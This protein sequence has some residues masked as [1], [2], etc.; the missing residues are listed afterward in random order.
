MHRRGDCRVPCCAHGVAVVTHEVVPVLSHWQ[1]SAWQST[2]YDQ[3][4]STF[5]AQGFDVPVL[6]GGTDRVPAPAL[7]FS[8]LPNTEVV[9]PLNNNGENAYTDALW[10]SGTL[11]LW[12]A[13][14]P[15]NDPYFSLSI[16]PANDANLMAYMC[17]DIATNAAGGPCIPSNPAIAAKAGVAPPVGRHRHAR[18]SLL[19]GA[20]LSGLTGGSAASKTTCVNFY[21]QVQFLDQVLLVAKA[22]DL[23]NS[24]WTLQTG[25]TYCS[26]SNTYIHVPVSEAEYTEDLAT[27]PW[28][29][30]NPAWC[31]AWGTMTAE[32]PNATVFTLR[33]QYDPYVLAGQDTKCTFQFGL[34]KAVYRRWGLQFL[35]LPGFIASVLSLLTVLCLVAR[36]RAA[37][38]AVVVKAI[39]DEGT[40]LASPPSI[41]MVRP[42]GGGQGGGY[43]AVGS[44]RGGGGIAAVAKGFTRVVSKV[45]Q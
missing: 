11:D 30:A 12:S 20:S 22:P 24:N 4:A 5:P 7:Q 39:V 18:R 35:L 37:A 15:T 33:S 38:R 9:E 45:K 3:F 43:G 41:A 29:G 10:F 19:A 42:S 32:R 44:P 17:S 2:Y 28:P 26:S 40:P 1:V 13:G 36:R 25:N 14:W 6:V 34:P 21:R 16:P 27:M 31:G 8:M 23:K